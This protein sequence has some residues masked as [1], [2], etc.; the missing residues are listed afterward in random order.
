MG[1]TVPT[2]ETLASLQK[3]NVIN[4]LHLPLEGCESKDTES[5][6]TQSK[7]QKIESKRQIMGKKLQ[8]SKYARR[9]IEKI[10]TPNPNK[11]HALVNQMLQD[12]VKDRYDFIGITEYCSNHEE[13]TIP[14]HKSKVHT[15]QVFTLKVNDDRRCMTL[16]V[17]SDLMLHIKGI[18]Q[19][20][21]ERFQ[22]LI[23]NNKKNWCWSPDE[24]LAKGSYK[25]LGQ[26]LLECIL[27]KYAGLS[28]FFVHVPND[29][30]HG[31]ATKVSAELFGTRISQ[32]NSRGTSEHPGTFDMVFG[33][34]ND[35]NGYPKNEYGYPDHIQSATG[36]RLQVCEKTP[37][38][39][40]DV[41]HIV[42][43]N[44]LYVLGDHVAKEWIYKW[45]EGG[46][47]TYSKVSHLSHRGG[48][49][50]SRGLIGSLRSL[51]DN[52]NKGLKNRTFGDRSQKDLVEPLL[53]SSQ[54]FANSLGV[55]VNSPTFEGRQ[56]AIKSLQMQR[57]EIAKAFSALIN[58]E[59][60]QK[61][62]SMHKASSM[63]SSL[64][65][66][67]NAILKALED[68]LPASHISELVATKASLSSLLRN[69]V[70]NSPTS[71]QRQRAEIAN[72]FST[73]LEH[74]VKEIT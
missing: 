52:I 23:S 2:E 60:T 18:Y 57:A 40:K 56:Q 72:T 4:I 54:A 70:V 67:L 35:G 21:E 64:Q 49:N 29:G 20:K 19:W 47:K 15:Y 9:N 45:N 41:P 22:P 14:D 25:F 42:E 13:I 61:A 7:R 33:D 43:G 55:F 66:L 30:P 10:E 3:L 11:A 69:F 1:E 68:S 71:S 28:I 73:F 34:F 65:Q 27:V 37:K 36:Y 8:K 24:S 5:W 63:L 26:C 12:C 74:C 16:L 44:T 51:F 17:Y 53:L 38:D 32:E 50:G 48:S 39:P 6:H 59:S 58:F 31:K 62:P 46:A